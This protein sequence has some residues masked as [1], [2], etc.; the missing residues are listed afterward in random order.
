MMAQASP[1][2]AEVGAGAVAVAGSSTGRVV[3]ATLR[4]SVAER[5]VLAATM[6]AEEPPGVGVGGKAVRVYCRREG[7]ISP[8]RPRAASSVVMVA[9]VA[10]A[11]QYSALPGR[12]ETATT[13]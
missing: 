8:Y 13:A 10:R 4:Q 7:A 12:E 1:L 11:M 5:V 9:M 2:V 3:S 6:A